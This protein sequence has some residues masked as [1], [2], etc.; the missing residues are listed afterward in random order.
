[1]LV[2]VI[3]LC[4]SVYLFIT[5]ISKCYTQKREHFSCK[6]HNYIEDYPY[7]DDQKMW[8]AEFSNSHF[9]K[10]LSNKQFIIIK[11]EIDRNLT[12]YLEDW[13]NTIKKLQKPKSK[14]KIISLNKLKDKYEMIVHR[15]GRNHGKVMTLRIKEEPKQI[16]INN[17]NIIGVKNEYE[18]S[19]DA[20][21][22]DVGN[23]E[24]TYELG[25]MWSV[26]DD[27]ILIK[28]SIE[29]ITVD[30]L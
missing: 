19:N 27:E 26:K 10:I 9:K 14:L 21:F 8:Y 15:N 29:R 7:T 17:I 18:I 24:L 22:N 2:S 4:M 13:L 6:K 11:E 1:M 12:G 28:D 25:D 3:L 20:L 23:M 5:I 30:D 16:I